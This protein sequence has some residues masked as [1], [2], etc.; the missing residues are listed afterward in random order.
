MNRIEFTTPAR[1]GAFEPDRVAHLVA[2]HDY[3]VHQRGFLF[4]PFALIGGVHAV[5]VR[6]F[7]I[8]TRFAEGREFRMLLGAMPAVKC[9]ERRRSIGAAR[10]KDMLRVRWLDVASEFL[11]LGPRPPSAQCRLFRRGR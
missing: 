5:L 4:A 7:K 6:P 10:A 11:S 8:A 3:R 9:A 2:T 1:S